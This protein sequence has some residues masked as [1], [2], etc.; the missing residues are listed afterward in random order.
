[1][2]R[3]LFLASLLLFAMPT[4]AREPIP[5]HLVGVWA[6]ESAVLNG[7]LLFEGAALWESGRSDEGLAR[8]S[9]YMD[10]YVYAPPSHLDYL[11]LF[12]GERL[13]SWR[14]AYRRLNPAGRTF[15][16]EYARSAGLFG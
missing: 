11:E 5:P 12:G 2:S 13:E 8:L 10:K 1:M 15:G 7:A 9:E 3:L 14:R 4:L 16:S 6:T